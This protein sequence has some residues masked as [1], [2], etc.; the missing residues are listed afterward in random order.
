MSKTKQIIVISIL[1]AGLIFMGLDKCGSLKK[2]SEMKGQFEEADRIAQ[3]EKGK[4]EA[5][6]EEQKKD[7][8]KKDVKIL[9]LSGEIIGINKDL[10][11]VKGELGEL[12]VEFDSLKECQVQYDKLVIA[13][14]FAESVIEKLGIPIEYYDELGVKHVKFPEGSITFDLNEKYEKQVTI[15]L[16]YKDMYESS[17]NL[18][19]IQSERVINLEKIN[20]RIKLVS[21]LKTG[22]GVLILIAII[23]ALT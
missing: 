22:A 11:G 16:A 15:S 20:K 5:V 12:K 10:T 18:L 19:R 21:S 9:K 4:K 2:A 7:I 14:N 6:I 3:I 23:G 1:C 17:E 13:F 8:E